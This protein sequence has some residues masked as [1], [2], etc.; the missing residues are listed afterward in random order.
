MS[1]RYCG[2]VPFPSDGAYGHW[3]CERQKFHLGRHRYRNYTVSRIP[4]VW[5]VQGLAHYWR[6][7]R[8]LRRLDMSRRDLTLRY[9]TILHRAKYDPVTP[10][11]APHE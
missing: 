11:G 5:D 6:G 1:D 2:Y 10:K 7:R 8:R 9:A 3:S 4:R